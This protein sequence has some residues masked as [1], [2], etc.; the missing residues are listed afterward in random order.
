MLFERSM[1]FESSFAYLAFRAFLA[2]RLLR[3]LALF[4]VVSRVTKEVSCESLFI[5]E[6]AVAVPAPEFGRGICAR[7]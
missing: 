1:S 5:F 6:V 7:C 4:W 2:V 3:V